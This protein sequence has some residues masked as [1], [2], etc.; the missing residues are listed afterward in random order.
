M[1]AALRTSEQAARYTVLN[2]WYNGVYRPHVEAIDQAKQ[3]EDPSGEAEARR[4]LGELSAAYERP[5]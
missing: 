5:K 4:I 2:T 1:Q 3:P